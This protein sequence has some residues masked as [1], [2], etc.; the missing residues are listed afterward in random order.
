MSN[1]NENAA[2]DATN[3]ATE[4]VETT[5][6]STPAEP[7]NTESTTPAD[8]N[9]F[10]KGTVVARDGDAG[11]S[12]DDGNDENVQPD[13]NESSKDANGGNDDD[14]VQPSS[15]D[16]I[17]PASVGADSDN[18]STSESDIVDVVTC[19][20]FKLEANRKIK[21]YK[22]ATDKVLAEVTGTL[23]VYPNEKTANGF[24]KC[25]ASVRGVGPESG[26]IKIADVPELNKYIVLD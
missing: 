6:N 26:Y 19:D 4:T 20:N 16:T 22:G 21:L 7:E 12:D 17:A 13:T 3:V 15:D 14:A 9:S 18:E 25:V 24:M 2:L 23:T 5:E 11:P 1:V 8:D 10:V